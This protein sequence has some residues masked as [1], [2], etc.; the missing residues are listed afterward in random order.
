MIKTQDSIYTHTE[1]VHHLDSSPSELVPILIEII[2]PK[3]VIDIGCGIGNFIAEFKKHGI[4]DVLG[5]DGIWADMDAISTNIG[6]KDFVSHDLTTTFKANRKYDL[7][8][9]LEVAEHIGIDYSD[10]FL[11]SL[12]NSGDEIVFSAALPNQGGQNH[13]NEQWTDFWV[14]KFLERGYFKKDIIKPLIWNNNNIFWWYRQNIMLFTKN[15]N[16]YNKYLDLNISDLIHKEN[17]LIKINEIYYLKQ[18]IANKQLIVDDY[19]KMLR[20]EFSIVFYLKKVLKSIKNTF[21]G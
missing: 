17:Y 10:K 13:I 20:G 16:K 4:N 1:D 14:D 2:N 18:I 19:Y 21:N 9:S 15:P 8:I 5:V 6:I 11:D 3:S 7:V 12:T